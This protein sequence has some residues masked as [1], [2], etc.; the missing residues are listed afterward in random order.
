MQVHNGE[1]RS[2]PRVA[3]FSPLNFVLN[4]GKD[5]LFL[6]GVVINASNSGLCIYSFIPLDRG[7]EIALSLSQQ[8]FTIQ[9]SKK[10]HN[11]F[12]MSGLMSTNSGDV[13][14]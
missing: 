4:P 10:L 12:Y 1:K 7:Q 13:T 11:D 6:D 8:K 5:N 9:W 14:P 2:E 3:L